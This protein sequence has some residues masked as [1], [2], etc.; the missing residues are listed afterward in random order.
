LAFSLHNSASDGNQVGSFLTNNAVAV[1][2][3]LFTV[4]LDFGNVFDGTKLWL[5]LGVRTNGGGT[6]T[7]LAPR[8]LITSEP[9]AVHAANAAR[10]AAV[11]AGNISG[12]IG[13]AQ[14]PTILITNGASGVSLSGT[15]GGDGAGVTNVSIDTINSS[16]A[17][18]WGSFAPSSTLPYYG[19]FVTSADVNGD[20]W[21][22]LINLWSVS[23]TAL[24]VLTNNRS[25][26]FQW[27][28]HPNVGGVPESVAAADING[29]GWVD[30]ISANFSTGSGD[31]L[32]VLTNNGN[33]GFALSSSP[34]V[35]LGTKTVVAADM[36]GDSKVDLIVT[37]FYSHSFVVLTNDGS[38]Q[39]VPIL[40]FDLGVAPYFVTVADVNHDGTVDLIS[41]NYGDDT[42]SVVTNDGSGGF[43]LSS[44]LEVGDGPISVVAADVNGD[45][46]VDLISA[47]VLDNTLSVMTNDGSGGFE[48]STYLDVGYFPRS[49]TAADVNGDGWVDLISADN[50]LLGSGNT[51]TVFTNNG[52]GRYVLSSSPAVGRGPN[53]VM[54]ADVNG[55]G[56]MDLVSANDDGTLSVLFNTR[57]FSGKFVGDGSELKLSSVVVTNGAHGVSLV[58]GTFSGD[59]SGLT[60]LHLNHLEAAD[61]NP[62]NAVL[63][64][65]TGRVG[66]GTTSPAAGLDVVGAAAPQLHVGTSA[67]SGAD[68]GIQIQ[69]ARSASTVANVAYL[70]FRDFDLDEGA[71]T[72]FVM[73][74]IAGG[75]ETFTGQ[76][77]NLRFFTANGVGPVERMRI[78]AGGNVGIGT[79]APEANLHVYSTDNPTTL[80]IQ[81]AGAPGFGRLAFV[82][83]PQGDANVWQPGYIQ[84]TDNGG[85]T[86]GL[87][88]Y[89]NGTGSGN[90]FG[91]NEVMRLVNGRVGIGT[92]N[93]SQALHVIG[94]ILATGT[95]TPNSDRNAK[96]DIVEV[97]AA[98]ILARVTE[99]PIRQW[100]FKAEGSGVKHVGPMAQDFRAAFGL[101][102]HET[103]IATVDA[104]GV[105]LAAIQGLNQK[106]EAALKTKDAEIQRLQ[107]TVTEL[108]QLFSQLTQTRHE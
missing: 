43:V 5:E 56:H 46:H 79:S 20:G 53:S 76:T 91:S 45:G 71:G 85:F 84:S 29:D 36:N 94:N 11:D 93:P 31:S 86:G 23:P 59:G 19:K 27:S 72:D 70:E 73:A 39:F 97:D 61:G 50:G 3:G 34:I 105:A 49:V 95:I 104:D 60:G 41:A 33:G 89:V 38:G 14:L 63:V 37:I 100:R 21:V 68:A 101:G 4:T 80:R 107:E 75:M 22:D 102:E 87:A 57:V 17:I 48:F 28:S 32:T 13:L 24:A 9:Y 92:N 12:T 44:L 74:K 69:G 98:A 8:H 18:T 10:A 40:A 26:G 62:A 88:F 108:K 90:K 52:S 58:D 81:S 7:T 82:S 30:L 83:N 55:D 103:A 64:D 2:N 67:T 65:A 16:G 77:G 66:I 96:T 35:G 15:F 78:Q 106:L 42:L 6:F 54:A 99:L 51:L 47:N 1:N 25:G